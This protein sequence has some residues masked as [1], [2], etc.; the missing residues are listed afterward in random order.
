MCM[1]VEVRVW[2]CICACMC[3]EVRVWCVGRCGDV[4]VGSEKK[5]NFALNTNFDHFSNCHHTKAFRALG[6]PQALQT[7]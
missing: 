3:V 6:F 7:L 4:Y 1:C 2:R 5:G